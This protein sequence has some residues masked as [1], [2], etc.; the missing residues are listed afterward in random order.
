MSNITSFEKVKLERLLGMDSGYVLSFSNRSFSEFILENSGMNIFNEKYNY[1]SGSKANRLRAFWK[2]EENKT[3]GKLLFSLIEYWKLQKEIG[4]QL[5]TFSENSLYE[6]CLAV[7]Q[8]LIN[9]QPSVSILNKDIGSIR[10]NEKDKN[11]EIQLSLLLSMFDDLGISPD[12]QK[13]GFLLQGLL[14]RLFLLNEISVTESF[15]RNNGGE[16]ID[17][18]FSYNGWFYLLECKWTKKLADIRELDSLYGKVTRSGKQ[19]M[20]LFLSIEGWSENVP[21]LLKQNQEKSIILMD[22][23]DLRCVLNK[24]IEFEVLLQ[25]KLSKLNHK[26]EPFCSAAEMLREN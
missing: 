25:K 23:Y 10:K 13:R 1:A 20:G 6:E 2:L 16:Q 3:V 14:N 7:T 18:A 21:L 22:G 11:K 26:S 9:D 17:G 8:R 5:V 15:Q 19:G 4:S 24:A 12:H